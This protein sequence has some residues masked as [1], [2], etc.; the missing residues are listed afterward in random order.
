MRSMP[1]TD[2]RSLDKAIELI[3]DGYSVNT[4]ESDTDVM[5][6]YDKLSSQMINRFAASFNGCNKIG[7][8]PILNL[9]PVIIRNKGRGLPIKVTF[10]GRTYPF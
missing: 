3:R 1:I 8:I 2:D 4:F 9:I 10:D 7:V 5:I 6:V